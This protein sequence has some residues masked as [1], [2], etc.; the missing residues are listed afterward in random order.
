M[1]ENIRVIPYK[2]SFL[3]ATAAFAALFAIGLNNYILLAI[4]PQLASELNQSEQTIGFLTSAYALPLALLAPLFGPLSDRIGRRKTMILG[5]I[6][7]IGASFACSQ[8]ANFELLM[9]GRM[10]T[11]LGAAIFIPASY[12]YVTDRST[13]E[14]RARAMSMLLSA[15][16][17]S[18]LVGL[19]VGGMI[20][21]SFGWRGVFG[22][23]GLVS[24]MALA[25]LWTLPTDSPASGPILG[26]REGLKR[27]LGSRTSLKVITITF[28]WASGAIGALTYVGQFFYQKYHF[29]TGQIG[30]V[31]M[32]IGV[33]GIV[34]TRTG[35]RLSKIVKPRHSV[36]VGIAGFGI[37]ILLLPWTNFVPLSMFILGI[38][39]F[40]TWFGLP[41]IQTIVSG[42]LPS[43]RGT[44]LSFNTSA[45]YL[46][47][48]IGAPVT[49][50]ILAMGGFPALGIWCGLLASCAFGLAYRVLPAD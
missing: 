20:A 31:L 41:A 18:A 33:V 45:Q 8:A 22:S 15:M 43:A 46:G 1:S 30:Q 35:V 48:V 36:L 21:S 17:A 34:A 3:P 6:V 50:V 5:M 42:L 29:T 38:W 49:G 26:Y 4:L 10:A 7:F 32:I 40:G 37:A 9:L 47:G 11:G 25:L 16:P 12:A 2:L 14:N 28:I 24:V 23:I 44:I 27:V 13:P 39:V 19:P